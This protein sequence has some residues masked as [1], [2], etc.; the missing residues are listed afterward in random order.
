MSFLLSV[1]GSSPVEIV[2]A[3]CGLANVVLILRRSLWN[4][5]FGFVMV[6]L[7]AKIFYDYQLYSDASLQL[8]FFAIQIFGLFWW[9]NGRGDDGLVQPRHLTPRT[10]PVWIAGSALGIAGLGGFMARYT[11]AALPWWDASIAV[12]SIVAQ[13]WLA[14][15]YIE[16]WYV[17]IAVDILAIGV[18]TAKGLAPT[19]V[20]YAVFLA[21]SVSGLLAW[22]KVPPAAPDT[23]PN[24]APNTVAATA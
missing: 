4:Y 13:T 14:R 18:F 3:L 12:L 6:A 17:W 7:Y 2:A 1:L 11:D 19:A 21:L 22:R 24:T 23:P 20:L 15:R 5:P 10:L 16:S 9:V 8:Y